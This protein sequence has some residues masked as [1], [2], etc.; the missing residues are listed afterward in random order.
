MGSTEL[1][2]TPRTIRGGERRFAV[3]TAGSAGLVLQTVLPALLK[4]P[5]AS[6]LTLEGGT[7]NPS[8][9]PFDALNDVFVPALACLGAQ[10]TL[11]LTRH[12]FFPAAAGA[13]RR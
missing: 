13:S 10:V 4:A 2:F 11:G 7:H 8:A 1:R 6:V 9:P 5:E 12:G 3:G